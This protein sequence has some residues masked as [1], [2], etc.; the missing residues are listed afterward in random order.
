MMPKEF[1]GRE[2]QKEICCA[3]VMKNSSFKCKTNIRFKCTIFQN[4]KFELYAYTELKSANLA[5]S[6]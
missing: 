5:C 3:H 4:Q 2:K 6:G 1:G